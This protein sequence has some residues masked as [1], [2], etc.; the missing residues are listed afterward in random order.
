MEAPVFP[1]PELGKEVFK[2]NKEKRKLKF[3]KELEILALVLQFISFWFAAPEIVGERILKKL[4]AWF[5]NGIKII[6]N[7][8][9]GSFLLFIMYRVN[10]SGERVWTMVGEAISGFRGSFLQC[11]LGNYSDTYYFSETFNGGR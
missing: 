6:M 2:Q 3:N 4:E 9:Q 11:N 7:I 10:V 8:I 5:V 1:N